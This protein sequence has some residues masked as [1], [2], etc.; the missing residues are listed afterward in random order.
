M[1]EEEQFADLFAS[2]EAG[3]GE[4][5]QVG[6]RIEGEIISI[7][8]DTVFINTGAKIDGAVDKAELLDGEGAFPYQVGDLLTLYVVGADETEIRLSRAISGI[9]GLNLLMDAHEKGVPVEGKVTATC[10]GGFHVDVLKRRAF[11]PVSQMDT[12]YVED[13]S[14]YVGQTFEFLVTRLEE[15]GRNIVVSRQA[16]LKKEQQRQQEA[17]FETVSVGDTVTGVVTNL[18][19]YGAFVELAPGL[20]GMVHVSELSWSRIGHPEEVVGPGDRISVKLLDVKPAEKTENWKISLSKKAAEAD[21]WETVADR[22]QVGGRVRGKVTRCAEFGAFVELSP[23]IEGLVHIS[24]LSYERRV[25]RVEDEVRPGESVEVMVKGI[26]LENRRISLSIRDAVGDPWIDVAEKY[27]KGR[28]I[29]GTVEKKERFGV[30][31]TLEPGVSGLMPASKINRSPRAGEIQKLNVGDAVQAVVSEI[32]PGQRRITLSPGEGGEGEADWRQYA[33]GEE[34]DA[35]ASLGSLG[36]KL[37][38][39]MNRKQKR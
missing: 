26:D 37:Q 31:I 14:A 20:E 35:P 3:G 29:E 9:G 6:D 12:R 16:L 7:G 23:G 21:P 33:Q 28:T 13:P 11:C 8:M 4:D 10:K 36:E 24:E 39:A 1:N 5:L 18:M 32:Q 27:P 38:Q 2:Y 17:F 15:K 19:P 22:F 34:A 25:H 30:F